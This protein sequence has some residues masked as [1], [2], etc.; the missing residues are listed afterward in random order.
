MRKTILDLAY[1]CAREIGDR[2][3]RSAIW[4]GGACTWLVV[5]E[6]RSGPKR[7]M[8]RWE[9]AQGSVYQGVS[10]IGL[11]LLDLWEETGDDRLL[12]TIIATC[13]RAAQFGIE[14]PEVSV[15]FHAGRTGIAFFL[16]RA[17]VALD[18]PDFANTASKILH[19]FV[20]R[21]HH[22]TGLDVIAGGAS[23]IPAMLRMARL[24]DQPALVTSAIGMG[25]VLVRRAH[26]EPSGWSWGRTSDQYV[27]RLTGFAHGAAGFGYG[28]LEL[29]AVVGDVRYRHAAEQAYAYEDAMFSESLGNWPDFR[30]QSLLT[31]IH[32][33]GGRE[34][35]RARVQSGIGLPPYKPAA[36]VAWCHGA[37]G[38]ALSRLRAHALLSDSTHVRAA[39]RA[40]QITES[41]LEQTSINHSLCHGVLGNCIPLLEGSRDLQDPRWADAV[42]AQL[43]K[44]FEDV[45]APGGRWRGGVVGEL[46]DPS[47][48]VGA[49]GIG[50]FMLRLRS[51]RV[52]PLT[53]LTGSEAP[54]LPHAVETG[55]ATARAFMREDIERY[56]SRSIQL[57]NALLP[58]DAPLPLSEQA[59]ASQH[60]IGSTY[61]EICRRS[62]SAASNE[63]TAML[64]DASSVERARYESTWGIVDM[65]SELADELARPLPNEIDWQ[66]DR[67]AP[68]S[69]VR[70]LFERYDWQ[71]W[72]EKDCAGPVSLLEVPKVTLL[73]RKDNSVHTRVPGAFVAKLLSSLGNGTK[74]ADAVT[75]IEEEIVGD[76]PELSSTLASSV[77][78][79]LLVLLRAG[80]VDRVQS[81]RGLQ[82]RSDATPEHPER[83]GS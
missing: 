51:S 18:R 78:A 14:L 43:Q 55:G 71:H 16:A 50:H 58:N 66:L 54:G 25:E 63:L 29:Y 72:L 19:A 80:I 24:L 20:G 23:A 26:R 59:D 33:P 83:S 65:T 70:L 41:N 22:D 79:Q 64:H 73:Y 34:D 49:A 75:A 44:V 81:A 57:F 28:L 15:G 4:S 47:F 46:D 9:P 60:E 10:G 62:N 40:L 52:L 48:M 56:F 17:A 32:E 12:P 45:G 39:V 13:N 82:Q 36:M 30:N 38:I 31:L 27:R 37:P 21:E 7:R 69:H 53:H 11:F 67:F 1:E 76:S 42:E 8:P 2:L 61:T 77:R 5:V 3:I 35:L 6:D 74:L 68:A